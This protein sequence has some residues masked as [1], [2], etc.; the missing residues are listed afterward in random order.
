VAIIGK[1]GRDIP[2]AH[3]LDHVLGWTIGN[4][5]TARDLQRRHGQWCKGKSLDLPDGA[6]D[7]ARG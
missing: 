1:A 7:R 6:G 3:A 2:K 4:D 5:M